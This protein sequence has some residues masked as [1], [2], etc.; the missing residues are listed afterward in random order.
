MKDNGYLDKYRGR[1]T[2]KLLHVLGRKGYFI[3]ELKDFIER[4]GDNGSYSTDTSSSGIAEKIYDE[5]CQ[6]L[7]ADVE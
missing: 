5:I 1:T 6:N 2:G 4:S 3:T 7:T